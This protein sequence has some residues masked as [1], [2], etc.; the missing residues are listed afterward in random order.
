MQ[1]CLHFRVDLMARGFIDFYL[2]SGEDTFE[3]DEKKSTYRCL[4]LGTPMLNI[5]RYFDNIR[6]SSSS[7]EAPLLRRN[8]FLNSKLLL[9]RTFPVQI[10][11]MWFK[12]ILQFCELDTLHLPSPCP[13]IPLQ[14][15]ST[16][17]LFIKY[18][19]YQAALQITIE[20][21][22]QRSLTSI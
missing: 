22:K 8:N 17:S 16:Q 12:T 7:F 5:F 19:T 4:S 15:A 10:N 9:K 13:C 6:V 20:E 14:S 11:N 2:D 21:L 3:N 1:F 18:V